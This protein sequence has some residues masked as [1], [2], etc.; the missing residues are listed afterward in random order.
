MAAANRSVI[1][2]DQ[3]SY[4]PISDPIKVSNAEYFPKGISVFNKPKI[5]AD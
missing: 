3:S 1:Q 4:S 2:A 5:Q